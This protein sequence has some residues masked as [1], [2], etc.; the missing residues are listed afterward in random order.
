MEAPG[1]DP[2]K[3]EFVASRL[4][5]VPGG[6]VAQAGA[7]GL[8]GVDRAARAVALMDIAAAAVDPSS[9]RGQSRTAVSLYRPNWNWKRASNRPP[10]W[11][12]QHARHAT[13]RL[14]ARALRTV[15]PHPGHVAST[16][17]QP[18]KGPGVVPPGQ[19]MR[20]EAECVTVRNPGR[21]A[22]WQARHRRA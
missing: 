3:G 15:T 7:V 18:P 19:M 21:P 11:R 4:A 8:E 13:A 16:P 20:P 14:G 2:A 17:T 9:R 12:L 22:A 5:A 6:E 1:R 10:A